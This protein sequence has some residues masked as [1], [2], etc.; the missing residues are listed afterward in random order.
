M[1][2]RLMGLGGQGREGR[3]KRGEEGEEGAPTAA[4]VRA[5]LELAVACPLSLSQHRPHSWC[6]SSLESAVHYNKAPP[7]PYND[8]QGPPT[9]PSPRDRRRPLSSSSSGERD[10]FY[11]NTE[12]GGGCN[13]MRGIA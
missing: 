3:D 11:E 9:S 5:R 8:E 13:E 2:E 12:G 7:Q 4:P 6:S 1:E 10:F